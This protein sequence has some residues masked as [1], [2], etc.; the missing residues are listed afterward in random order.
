MYGK[1]SA[2]TQ[3]S[4]LYNNLIRNLYGR[5]YQDNFKLNRRLT[6]NLGLRWNPFVQF[7]GYPTNQVSIFD[8]RIQSG[9]ALPAFPNLPPGQLAGR[10]SVPQ[11]GCQSN[12]RAV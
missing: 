9:H 8:E 10:R 6:L 11:V 4:P 2:F 3:I 7:H 1:P 5:L 12:L